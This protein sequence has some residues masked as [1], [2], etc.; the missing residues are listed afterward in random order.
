MWRRSPVPLSMR[1]KMAVFI[2]YAEVPLRFKGGRSSFGHEHAHV[3]LP[4]FSLPP[5]PYR[6]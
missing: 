4:A 2:E 3:T 5:I 1:S 6:C